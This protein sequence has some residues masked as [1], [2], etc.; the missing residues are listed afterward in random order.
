MPNQ[1][2][3]NSPL[4]VQPDMFGAAPQPFPHR[5]AAPVPVAGLAQASGEL[6]QVA[7][8]KWAVKSGSAPE[9]IIAEVFRH[10]DGS[11]GFRP[12]G[13]GCL[14]KLT[15]ELGELLGFSGQLNTVRRLH[16]AG[17]IKFYQPSPC[18]YMLDLDSWFAHLDAT[19]ED[20]DFWD[21]EGPNLRRYLMANGLRVK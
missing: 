8:G 2:P 13:Y 5:P 21:P 14:A 12:S 18:V 20:P 11:L 15:A 9:F 3:Q 19:E 4:L 6:I 1:T 17:F 16:R 10:A 7:P